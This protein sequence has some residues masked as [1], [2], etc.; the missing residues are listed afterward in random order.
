MSIIKGSNTSFQQE[1]NVSFNYKI[2]MEEV[3]K[4][5][6]VYVTYILKGKERIA[7]FQNGIYHSRNCRS[8][9]N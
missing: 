4:M 2:R 3:F 1:K 7:T 9:Q 8:R 6:R 5:L